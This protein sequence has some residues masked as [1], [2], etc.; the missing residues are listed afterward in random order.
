[1]P[2][3][4]QQACL[5]VANVR[6]LVSVLQA[7]KASSSNQVPQQCTACSS[8]SL[9]APLTVTGCLVQLCIVT[10]HTDGLSVCWEDESKSLQAKVFLRKEVLQ[11]SAVVPMWGCHLR[12]C[13]PL[14]VSLC[15]ALR[16]V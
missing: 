11:N 3:T 5:K 15:T 9:C 13:T 14:T 16:G 2:L 10:L 4:P 7:I 8:M 12:C 6:G 1:M